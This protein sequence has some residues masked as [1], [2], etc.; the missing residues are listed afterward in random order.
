MI[1]GVSVSALIEEYGADKAAEEYA[2]LNGIAL[3]QARFFIAVARG[4]L[5]GD[6]Y[7]RMADGGLVPFPSTSPS[8]ADRE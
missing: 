6:T 8:A 4:R 1:D 3:E 7:Q 5:A 2:R